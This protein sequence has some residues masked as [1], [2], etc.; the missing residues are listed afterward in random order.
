MEIDG[1][2][3]TRDWLRRDAASGN[4]R[5][6]PE[7]DGARV[8]VD[9]PRHETSALGGDVAASPERRCEYGRD[10]AVLGAHVAQFRQHR[11]AAEDP[12]ARRMER[13]RDSASGPFKSTSGLTAAPV[14]RH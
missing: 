11:T 4:R 5:R 2:R 13:S 14:T 6:R 8:G 12:R 10:L 3:E 9:R 7:V 1:I